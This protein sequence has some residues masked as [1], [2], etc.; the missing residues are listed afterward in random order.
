MH[1]TTRRSYVIR[2]WQESTPLSSTPISRFILEN[3]FTGEQQGFTSVELL[4]QT[5]RQVLQPS[6]EN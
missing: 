1:S 4:L 3:T 5:L 6:D 2:T